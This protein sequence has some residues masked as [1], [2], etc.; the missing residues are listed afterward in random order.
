M[1]STRVTTKE[2][3]V[4]LAGRL[5]TPVTSELAEYDR[6]REEKKVQFPNI[7]D[8]GITL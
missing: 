3:D 8:L 5:Q 7:K 2:V 4:K 6:I 1:F